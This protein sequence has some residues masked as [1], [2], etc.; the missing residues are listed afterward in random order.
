MGKIS[1]SLVKESASLIK[2]LL[3]NATSKLLQITN[4][5]ECKCLHTAPKV[6]AHS[7]THT[8]SRAHT[9]THT[10]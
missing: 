4:K 6:H 3:K 2:H 10:N 8:H 5:W 9:H 1:L 7:W